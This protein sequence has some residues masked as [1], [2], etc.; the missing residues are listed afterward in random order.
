MIRK[1]ALAALMLLAGLV[2][3]AAAPGTAEL[4]MFDDPS[5]VW[6]RRWNA[7]IG[8]SYPRTAEG[9]LAPLRRVNI[10]QQADAGIALARP[11]RGTPTFVL[12][13]DGSEIGRIDGYAGSD[14]FYPRLAELLKLLPA[15]ARVPTLR[16]TMCVEAAC[17][18]R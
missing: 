5:C 11:V 10:R 17:Q 14:F 2:A 3:H 8:P 9:R 18:P 13:H 7:E 16:S 15:P 1:L 6:C 4:V 12:V